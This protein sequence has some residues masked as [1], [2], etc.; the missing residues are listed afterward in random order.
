[1][2]LRKKMERGFTLIDLV[3]VSAVVYV[4]RLVLQVVQ[5]LQ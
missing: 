4:I 5:H 2:T 3:A 1:M